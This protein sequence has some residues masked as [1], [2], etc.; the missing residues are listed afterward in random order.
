[1]ITKG[2][3]RHIQHVTTIGQKLCILDENNQ[4]CRNPEAGVILDEEFY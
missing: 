1:M 4:I 3:V 2:Q